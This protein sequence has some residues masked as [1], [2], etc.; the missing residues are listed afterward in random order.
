VSDPSS[1]SV[2][3]FRVKYYRYFT[4]NAWLRRGAC[5]HAAERYSGSLPYG[6]CRELGGPYRDVWQEHLPLPL[7]LC[8]L[9][10][11]YPSPQP[12]IGPKAEKSKMATVGPSV[13]RRTKQPS[14]GS[15]A[16]GG[17]S[18]PSHLAP[19]LLLIRVQPRGARSDRRAT[20]IGPTRIP[21]CSPTGPL[22]A[23]RQVCS[24]EL[25]AP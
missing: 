8:P 10:C 23:G 7:L 5:A 18:Y 24:P 21:G 11:H 1:L 13:W 14:P 17:A 16:R 6:Q 25:R 9:E 15:R 19:L 2:P 3:L 22:P 12:G 20:K 4:L